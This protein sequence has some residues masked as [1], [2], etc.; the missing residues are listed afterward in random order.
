LIGLDTNVLV[1]YFT[2]DD[3]AQSR[4]ARTVMNTLSIDEPG[5]VGLATILELVWVMKSVLRLDRTTIAGMIHR[6]LA[7]DSIIVE[8]AQTIETA[9][10]CYRL[11]KADFADC[12]IAA[13]ARAAGCSKTVTFDQI[14]A[15]DT[16]ME[17]LS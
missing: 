8:Q 14:A 9:L 4:R 7:G 15:R 10:R 2:A 1:R 3:P 13:S 12:L 5:W 6:L 17:L 11:G 16:G